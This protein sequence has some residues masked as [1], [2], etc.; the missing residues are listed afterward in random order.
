MV[1]P[2]TVMAPHFGPCPECG[3]KWDAA[4]QVTPL[5]K[6]ERVSLDI[7]TYTVCLNCG[8]IVQVGVGYVPV[9]T[10]LEKIALQEQDLKHL[11]MIGKLQQEA[12]RLRWERGY[13][14]TG[15]APE[16]NA[17][18]LVPKNATK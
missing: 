10:T 16:D 4:T 8:Q 11:A 13:D 9:P 5:G 1:E 18:A 15:G 6:G 17:R 7:G 2:N 3:Y 12:R 14:L